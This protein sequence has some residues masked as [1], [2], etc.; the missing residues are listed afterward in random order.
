MARAALCRRTSTREI[1]ALALTEG[2]VGDA[3]QVPAMRGQVE[4][5]IA[6]VM[7][8][9]AYDGEPTYAAAAPCQQHPLPEVAVPPRASAVPNLDYGNCNAQNRRDRRS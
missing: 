8:D 5:V 6:S 4:D 1:A 9:G 7:E 3:A 2:H